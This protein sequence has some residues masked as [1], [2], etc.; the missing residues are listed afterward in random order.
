M[1]SSAITKATLA[2]AVARTARTKAS[3]ALRGVD[4]ASPKAPSLF[5][6]LLACQDACDVAIKALDDAKKLVKPTRSL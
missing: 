1:G 3:Q 6:K 2:L 4:I 5:A